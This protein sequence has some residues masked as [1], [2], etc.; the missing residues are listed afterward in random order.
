MSIYIVGMG[1]GSAGTLTSQAAEAITRADVIIGARR[2]LNSL[3]TACSAVTYEAIHPEEIMRHIHQNPGK[4]ICILMSGDIGFYSG[5]R[6]LLE[7]LDGADIETLPGISSVQYFAAKLK[8]PWQDWTLISAHGKNCPVVSVVCGNAE[9]FFLTGGELTVQK[10]CA[11][12]RDAGLGC[13]TV[14]VGENLGAANEAI[15]TGTA[16]NLAEAAHDMLAVMLVDNPC[17]RTLVSSGLPDSA[18]I[19]G[20][21]PMTKSEVRSVI[22]SKLRL[23]ESDIIYDVGAGTGSVSV[24]AALLAKYGHVYAFEQE[25]EGCRLIKEN[26]KKLQ[27]P[28][29]TCIEGKAPSSFAGFPAPDAAFIGGSGGNLKEI[30]NALLLLSPTVRLVI[31]AVTL[32]TLAEA[33]VLFSQLRIQEVD[34][35]QV[36]V[37]RARQM[38]THHLMTAQNPVFIISGMGPNG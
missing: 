28:N 6:K 33:A 29:L 32:E 9:T 19:R 7:L 16:S 1:M 14:T 34:I 13:L 8:R 20:D 26:A 12:L 38:G 4:S 35:V 36:S 22:L 5:A 21:I 25:P 10:I 11:E 15:K 2:L 23:N 31:S 37:S 30:L 27:A 17:P 24:E 18:F 3:P